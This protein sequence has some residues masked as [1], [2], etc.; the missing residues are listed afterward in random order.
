MDF[1][2]RP[3]DARP[4]FFTPILKVCTHAR[5]CRWQQ[6]DLYAWRRKTGYDRRLLELFPAAAMAV[7]AVPRCPVGENAP[8][9]RGPRQP[10][11]CGGKSQPITV[12]LHR[13]DFGGGGAACRASVRPHSLAPGTPQQPADGGGKDNVRGNGKPGEDGVSFTDWVDGISFIVHPMGPHAPS[14]R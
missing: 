14:D 7:I 12:E 9:R 8:A 4:S 5:Q 6:M 13:S 3:G 2:R 10:V 1:R 11:C